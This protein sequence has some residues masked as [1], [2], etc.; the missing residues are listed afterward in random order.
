[1]PVGPFGPAISDNVPA[2]SVVLALA[3]SIAVDAAGKLYIPDQYWVDDSRGGLTPASALGRL[4]MVSDG[5]ITT[6][7]GT[8]IDSGP[9]AASQLNLPAGIALDGAGNLYIADSS[10]NIVRE[11]AN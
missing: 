2:T 3:N 5:T 6:I 10:N 11:I 8:K 4:R 1:S 9:A 7:A